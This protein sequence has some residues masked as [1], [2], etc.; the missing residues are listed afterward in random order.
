[1]RYMLFTVM[2]T[3]QSTPLIH[4]ALTQFGNW[5]HV[6]LCHI[7]YFTFISVAILQVHLV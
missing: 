5:R 1:M 6:N 4:S 3:T 7:Y 2:M